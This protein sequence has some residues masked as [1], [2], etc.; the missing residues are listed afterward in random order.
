MSFQDHFSARAAVYA[1]A[2]PTY[3]PALFTT[4][5]ALAPGRSLA[6]DCGTGNG[7]AARGL[8]DHFEKVVA[9]DPSEA[10]LSRALAHHRIEYRVAMEKDS[11]LPARSVDLVAAAQAAHWFDMQAFGAE[12]RRV[13]RPGGIVAVWCYNLLRISPA[14]DEQIHRF[15]SKTVG[16]YWPPERRHTEAGYRTLPF[17]FPELDFPDMVMQQSWT[18]EELGAYLTTWSA[19]SRFTS[20]TGFDPVDPFLG[21]LAKVWGP[22]QQRRRIEWPLTGRLGRLPEKD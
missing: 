22:P 18:L 3:P 9:S 17:P 1:T 19:V 21:E 11:G 12:V 15:Y 2:R 4:L 10:Q 8:A 5:S 16:P 13:L 7:Q 14:I 20:E 6:W